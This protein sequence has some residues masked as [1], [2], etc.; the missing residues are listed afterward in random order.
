MMQKLAQYTDIR[1]ALV[2]GGLSLQ[3]QAVTLKSNPE[4]IVATPVRPLFSNHFC[5]SIYAVIHDTL[6]FHL[7]CN[8]A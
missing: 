5:I 3:V 1:I 7:K 4:V 2:V 6:A 8:K